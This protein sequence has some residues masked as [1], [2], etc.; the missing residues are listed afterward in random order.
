MLFENRGLSQNNKTAK[1]PRR[2]EKLKQIFL[3]ATWQLG[4][5]AV[6]LLRGGHFIYSY[7][8]IE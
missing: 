3:L 7:Y 2:Q 4:V 8:L 1:A 6:V 5:L